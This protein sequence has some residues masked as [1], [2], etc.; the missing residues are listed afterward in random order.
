MANKGAIADFIVKWDKMTTNVTKNAA[1]LPPHIQLYSAPLQEVLEELR[2]IG[3]AKNASRAVKQQE[4]K[5]S[6]EL[7]TKGQRLARKLQAALVAHHGPDSELLIA[8]DIPPRRPSRRKPTGQPET[9][10]PENPGSAPPEGKAAPQGAGPSKS[11]GP[12]P[13]P[14]PSPQKS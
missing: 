13:Q 2:A 9:P 3:A 7:K 8:Y 6:D 11:E 14:D 10:Q 5:D 1:E 12:A 4:V